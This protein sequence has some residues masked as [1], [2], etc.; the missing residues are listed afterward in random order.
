MKNK[1]ISPCSYQGGKQRLAKQIVD[2]IFE[3]N[4]INK[5]T[6]FYDLCCGSGAITLELINRGIHPNNI[7]MIDASMWGKFW[8]SI[9]NEE[10]ELDVFRNEINKLPEIEGIQGYLKKINKNEVDYDLDIYHFLLQQAGSFGSKCVDIKEGKWINSSFRSYW[11]PTE[12]SNRKSV[13]NPMMPMP[14]TLYDRVKN[15]V[16]YMSGSIK[17]LYCK[18][19]DVEWHFD[20]G[21]IVY[22]DPPYKNTS[23][24]NFEFD[25]EQFLIDNWNYVNIYVSEG[26]KI[27]WCTNAILLSKG[28]KKGNI[29]GNIK[30]KQTEEWLN[31]YKIN[32]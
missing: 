26:Y 21:D 23:G 6:K 20:E 9:A 30:K 10:F 14:S 8:N 17:A 24:Y 16:D 12:T 19:E 18:I 4:K 11:R 1:L 28:R 32:N 2:I 25:Y 3:Q 7:T 31:I 29:N 13:V 15:I 27:D 22:I 5:N